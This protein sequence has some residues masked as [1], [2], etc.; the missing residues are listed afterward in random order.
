M[1]PDDTHRD[2]PVAHGEQ[3]ADSTTPAT[4]DGELAHVRHHVTVLHLLLDGFIQHLSD[5][6]RS[7][8]TRDALRDAIAALERHLTAAMEMTESR[9][10]LTDLEEQVTGV[11]DHV[12]FVA[13]FLD[14]FLRGATRLLRGERVRSHL[15][16]A[17]LA[18]DYHLEQALKLRTPEARAAVGPVPVSVIRRISRAKEAEHALRGVLY[19]IFTAGHRHDISTA[20]SRRGFALLDI[21]HA[22][23]DS[24]T[25]WAGK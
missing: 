18:I 19:P 4:L 15:S 3:T 2:R 20:D 7:A 23:L 10:E 12:Q 6:L 24:L 17:L 21:I 22:E 5:C 8:D 16:D 9:R 14:G 13:A 1:S 11:W 25:K